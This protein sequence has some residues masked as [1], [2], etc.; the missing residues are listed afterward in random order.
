MEHRKILL[1]MAVLFLWSSLIFS[2]TVT[3]EMRPSHIDLS[4]AES[5]SAVLVTIGGYPTDLVRYRLYSGTTQYNCWDGTQY[6]TSNVYA[7][8]P[9]V[10]GDPMVSSTWWI[11]HQRGTN[12]STSA[13]YRDRLGPD[14]NQN[15]QTQALTAAQEITNPVD[16]DGIIP[17]AGIHDLTVK[18][19]VL[20]FDAELGGTLI[21]AASTELNTG[22]YTLVTQT[23]VTIRRIEFRTVLDVTIETIT[24]EWPPEDAVAPPSFDPPAG[25]Y[26]GEISVEIST[27]T[28]DAT[29]HYTT[30]GEDPTQASPIYT[31]PIIVDVDMTIKARGYA[32]DLDPSPISIANYVINLPDVIANVAALRAAP[33]DGTVYTLSDEVILTYQQTWRNQKFIQD[34]TG[35]ILIDDF[36]GIITTGYNV[37]DGISNLVGTTNTFGQMVQFVPIQD[38]GP[39]T[40]ED[41]P[42]EAVTIT[43]ADFIADIM[44]YQSRLV[45]IHNV[46]FLDADGTMVFQNGTIYPVS[47]TGDTIDFRTTFYGEDYIGE[48]IPVEELTL[49]GIPNSRTEG[50]FITARNSGDFLPPASDFLIDIQP[51]SADFGVIIVDEISAPVTFTI[52]NDN[53]IEVT[54]VDLYLDGPNAAD[55]ILDDQNIYPHALAPTATMSIS[56]SFAP[57]VSGLHEAYVEFEVSDDFT[58][59][60]FEIPLSGIG[61]ELDA[62]ENLEAEIVHWHDVELTW[63]SPQTGRIERHRELIG[64]DVYRNDFLI[65]PDTPLPPETTSFIDHEVPAGDNNYQVRAVYTDTCAGSE[66]VSLTIQG[67]VSAVEMDPEPGEYQGS[68]EVTLFT[69]TDDAEIYFTLDGEDP[70]DE[71]Y[72]YEVPILLAE[73][74]TI[75]A[76]AFNVGWETSSIST[77][78]YIIVVSVEED[79]LTPVTTKL[80]ANYP[81]P[82]NPDTVIFFTLERTDRVTIEIFDIRGKRVKIL[83]DEVLTSGMHQTVW[84]G[85][86]NMGKQM[87]SGVYFYRM[88]TSDHNEIRKMIL[89]K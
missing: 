87:P 72:L 82:F 36:E 57:V 59:E 85:N 83:V 51:A 76:R 84:R 32:V 8:G 3:I 55:F 48:V 74:T 21:T 64:Y 9:L 28:P 79:D 43:M 66:I 17:N 78:E 19:V 77:G 62:P 16:I 44:D 2:Q 68:I 15:Y 39:A 41:N 88:T 30:D 18:Y 12:N 73:D 71:S 61:M 24:G 80:H 56:V 14:Y 38:P 6:V 52:T 47:D 13:N 20:G 60:F 65:S 25:T 86:D 33:Q 40:S 42:I 11:L 63:D 27:A 58:S 22:A 50:H 29:I 26:Y 23:G 70:T 7:N 37:G 81:N 4:T 89:I 45:K 5:E 69:A 75:K 10:P 46:Q 49:Q 67:P 53:D 31:D 1:V 34:D 54:V 35:G